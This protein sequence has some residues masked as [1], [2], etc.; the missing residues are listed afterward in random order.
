[1][2]YSYK[3]SISFGLVYIPIKL[4][5]C[6]RENEIKF[7]QLDRRNLARVRYTKTN[8]SDGK[9]VEQKDIVKGYRY[10]D[11]KYVVLTDDDFEKI[12]TPKEKSITIEQFADLN[13]ID[14]V[15]FD[16]PYYVVPIGGEKAFVLLRQTLEEQNKVGIAKTVLG[17]KETLVA[18]RV[19][20][21][22]MLLSTLHFA[23]DIR[24]N[25]VAHFDLKITDAEADMAKM[26]VQNMTAPFKPERFVD[27]YKQRVMAAIESKV[28]GKQIVL[29]KQKESVVT[30]LM[31]ALIQSVQQTQTKGEPPKQKK[32]ADKKAETDAPLPKRGTVISTPSK[33]PA[34]PPKTPSRR[35]SSPPIVAKP[36]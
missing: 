27:E 34:A 24:K 21:G 9:T 14:P 3:G 8:E 12:K 1:M 29:P 7:N 23:A 35:K 10:E 5:K 20:N 30:D 28:A 36:K 32:P 15:Y 16:T 17:T 11:D 19:K 13:E 2:A 18:L 4:E 25:P 31:D 6:V 26:L 33:P 22:E